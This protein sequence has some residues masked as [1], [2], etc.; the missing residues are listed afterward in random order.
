M[1]GT[2]CSSRLGNFLFRTNLE[3]MMIVVVALTDVSFRGRQ[4]PQ[5]GC[6]RSLD[7]VRV[8]R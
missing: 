4:G 7:A 5:S 8:G 1:M 3:L 6:G 2:K